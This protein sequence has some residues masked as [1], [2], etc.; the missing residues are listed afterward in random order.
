MR[1]VTH[2]QVLTDH[3]TLLE[4]CETWQQQ[5]QQSWTS[6]ELQ[7]R[8]ARLALEYSGEQPEDEVF[9]E[10]VSM[11]YGAATKKPG[12]KVRQLLFYPVS[13]WL[14]KPGMCGIAPTA[15]GAPSPRSFVNLG[16]NSCSCIFVGHSCCSCKRLHRGTR[17][18]HAPLLLN[19]TSS[20]GVFRHGHRSSSV[21]HALVRHR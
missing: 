20:Q 8:R 6:A 9:G 10:Q 18:R 15:L 13:Y 21:L 1:V 19:R 7:R 16:S 2:R 4:L 5:E 3:D 12:Y 17:W 11:I 14:F